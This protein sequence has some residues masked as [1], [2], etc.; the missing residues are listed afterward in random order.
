MSLL[1]RCTE[2]PNLSKN[3]QLCFSFPGRSQVL[4]TVFVF[5]L[6]A[7]QINFSFAVCAG[8][9]LSSNWERKKRGGEENISQLPVCCQK[10]ENIYQALAQTILISVLSIYFPKSITETIH[11]I[12]NPQ[13]KQFK[14]HICRKI[15]IYRKQ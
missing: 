11:K 14:A 2:V 6:C 8:Q 15:L 9:P 13:E 7:Q 4:I 3:I 5:K 10:Q 12:H 1:K